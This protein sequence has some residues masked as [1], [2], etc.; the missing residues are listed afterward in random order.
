MEYLTL[1]LWSSRCHR[2]RSPSSAFVSIATRVEGSRARVDP[3]KES[4]LAASKRVFDVRP[5]I[6]SERSLA[7]RI[8]PVQHLPNDEHAR[9]GAPMDLFAGE[10]P[11]GL[12]P[13]STH[14]AER[15][16]LRVAE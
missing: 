2:N 8:G 14:V 12:S 1:V 5:D 16:E 3:S 11:L 10:R 13:A 7:A 6:E 15:C 4:T 9:V